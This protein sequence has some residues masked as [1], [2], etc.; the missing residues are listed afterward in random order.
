MVSIRSA[1]RT[2]PKAGNGSVSH[3]AIHAPASKFAG[4]L[5]HHLQLT[6]EFREADDPF[7][8]MRRRLCKSRDTYGPSV[9]VFPMAHSFEPVPQ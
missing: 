2:P 9:L 3:R 4:V 6:R 7:A 1:G 8:L 5:D